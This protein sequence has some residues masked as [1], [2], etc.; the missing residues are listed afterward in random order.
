MTTKKLVIAGCTVGTPFLTL[1]NFSMLCPSTHYPEACWGEQAGALLRKGP[2]HLTSRAGNGH[3][4][5]GG[6]NWGGLHKLHELRER[7]GGCGGEGRGSGGATQ[8]VFPRLDSG[9]EAEK[10]WQQEQEVKLQKVN[11]RVL[12]LF[13]F[14]QNENLLTVSDIYL[15]ESWY[16]TETFKK[17]RDILIWIWAVW[18][19]RRRPR[20]KL[21][22]TRHFISCTVSDPVILQ[23]EAIF[24]RCT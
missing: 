8:A 24:N 21:Q 4:L 7:A 6:I 20:I 2:D 23:N 1:I 10:H 13:L 16:F 22:K 17:T 19:F 12:V 18:F 14:S 15:Q 9:H 3:W 11:F 5:G